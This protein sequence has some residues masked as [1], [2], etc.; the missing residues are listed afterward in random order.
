MYRHFYMAHILQE[1][2]GKTDDTTKTDTQQ[3]DKD[4]VSIII[5]EVAP[6]VNME[7]PPN[8]NDLANLANVATQLVK[9][10]PSPNDASQHPLDK[11]THLNTI[12]PLTRSERKA[13]IQTTCRV[14]GVCFLFSVFLCL[15]LGRFCA[16]ADLRNKGGIRRPRLGSC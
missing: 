7:R 13:A 10:D 9:T 4:I 3:D 11:D 6:R 5:D 16:G 14:Q 1:N 12:Q 8:S 15:A 2:D